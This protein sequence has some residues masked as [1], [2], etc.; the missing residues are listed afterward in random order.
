MIIDIGGP[1]VQVAVEGARLAALA[2]RPAVCLRVARGTRT[3]RA[4]V[5]AIAARQPPGIRIRLG[6]PPAGADLALEIGPAEPGGG[7]AGPGGRDRGDRQGEVA[8]SLGGRSRRGIALVP[9][10]RRAGPGPL[11]SQPWQTAC[12]RGLPRSSPLMPCRLL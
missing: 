6:P 11:A 12:A 7:Q 2:A 3:S 5:A 10:R 4:A 1:G 8:A 9:P